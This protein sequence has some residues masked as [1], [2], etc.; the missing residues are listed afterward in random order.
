MIGADQV[1]M[2]VLYMI[3]FYHRMWAVGGAIAVADLSY[4]GL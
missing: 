4:Y 2:S 3:L 1:A